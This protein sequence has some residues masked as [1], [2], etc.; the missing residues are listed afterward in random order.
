MSSTIRVAAV[1]L[2]GLAALI[3]TSVAEEEHGHCSGANV[4]QG[5]A[6]CEK[7]GHKELTKEECTKIDGAKFEPSSHK[8][9]PHEDPDHMDKK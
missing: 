9:E 1:T 5:D 4:C 8:N 3:G 6:A 2:F 7:V